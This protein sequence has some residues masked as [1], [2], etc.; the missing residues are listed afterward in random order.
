MMGMVSFII[1]YQIPDEAPGG[2]PGEIMAATLPTRPSDNLTLIPW[3]WKLECVRIS[4]TVPR[5][6]P[7]PLVAFLDNI[8]GHTWPYVC[9]LLSSFVRRHDS[10]P[11]KKI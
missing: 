11:L 1:L 5:V 6:S 7:A 4:F 3:G 8:H 2:D 10:E 9:P